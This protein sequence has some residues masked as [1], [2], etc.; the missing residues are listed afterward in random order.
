MILAD[1]HMHTGFS[2][3]SEAAPEEMIKAAIGKGLKAVCITDHEDKDYPNPEE[4][5]IDFPRYVQTIDKLKEA[6]R[7]QIDVRMGVEIGL[8]PHLGDYYRQLTE[9][10]SFDF[11]IGSVHVVR[12]MDPYYPEFYEGRSD[13]DAYRETLEETIRD[14]RNVPDF[15]TLGHLDYVVRYGRKKAEEYSY[16]KFSDQ[17][18]EILRLLIW[19]GKGLELNTAGLKYGLPF[20]HPHPDVLRRYRELGG[21]IITVGSDAHRPEHVAYDFDK[22]AGILTQCGFR[23]YAEFIGRKPIF[24]KIL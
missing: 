13:A 21:E 20:A 15:D 1:C 19:H 6:Y 18:D 16:Q 9:S 7:G 24:Q 22:A 11:V 10:Y 17:I 5:Y 3:D 4:F 12:G 2:T 14:I 8:Q 23:Y